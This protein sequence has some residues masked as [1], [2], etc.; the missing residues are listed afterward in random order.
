M[1]LASTTKTVFGDVVIFH[2]D[3]CEKKYTI[4]KLDYKNRM[5]AFDETETYRNAIEKYEQRVK[6]I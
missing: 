6:E 4:T 2:H 5:I 3:Q 1:L